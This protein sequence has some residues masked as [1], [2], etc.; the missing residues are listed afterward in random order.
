MLLPHSRFTQRSKG[1]ADAIG[2][3][4]GLYEWQIEG[5]GS[6][7]GKYKR[8]SRPLKHYA[9]NIKNLLRGKAYQKGKP[10]RF[11]RIHHELADAVRSG[12]AIRLIILENRSP[13]DINQREQ[14]Q[15]AERGTLNGP[16]VF[17]NSN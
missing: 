5:V 3:L 4:P 12:K 10:S 11:R 15:I 14:E 6:Y 7:I 17:L 1:R 13:A 2:F 8:I 16:V 9:R